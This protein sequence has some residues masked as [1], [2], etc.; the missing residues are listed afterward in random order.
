MHSNG[1]R[2]FV[3]FSLAALLIA[4][5]RADDPPSAARLGKKIDNITLHDAAGKPHS[6]YDL[7]DKKAIVIVFLSFDCPVSNGYA[8]PLAELAKNY[9]ERGVAFVGVCA[10]RRRRGH[11]CQECQGIQGAVSGFQRRDT[12]RRPTHCGR[13]SRHR[14]LSSTGNSC[15]VTEAGLMTNTSRGSRRKRRSRGSI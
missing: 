5:A 11:D 13:R 9:G 7:K 2:L 4:P 1:L 6:L 12:R 10:T 15:C 8:Q 14:H 3:S